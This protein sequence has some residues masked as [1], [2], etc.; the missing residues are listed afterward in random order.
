MIKVT[1]LK[2]NLHM[3]IVVIIN[4]NWKDI[5]QICN[6]ILPRKRESTLLLIPKLTQCMFF[7]GNL[8]CFL[9]NAH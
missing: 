8:A 6:A 2:F 1:N 4:S 9:G 7:N 3:Q 5:G